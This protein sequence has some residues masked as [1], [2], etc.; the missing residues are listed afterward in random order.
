MR[1]EDGGGASRSTDPARGS[2][3]GTDVS[4]REY[5]HAEIQAVEHRSEARFESMQRAVDLALEANDRR[6][7]GVN[8]FRQTLSDQAANF[9]TRDA[10]SSLNEKLQ[11]A[12][13]RNSAD[14]RLLSQRIDRREGEESGARITKGT[15]YSAL[16]V[17]IA[18]LGIFIALANYFTHR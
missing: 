6:F 15:L 3:E 9:V 7:E 17:A 16:V 11:A 10:M 2:S 14:L 5:L 13:E 8:E 4:L 1:K 12:I 18:A